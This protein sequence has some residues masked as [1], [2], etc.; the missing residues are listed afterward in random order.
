MSM[1][2]DNKFE[3]MSLLQ[4]ACVSKS[5]CFILCLEVFTTSSI[6]KTVRFW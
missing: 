1:I 5:C 4:K 2:E 3:V 6:K